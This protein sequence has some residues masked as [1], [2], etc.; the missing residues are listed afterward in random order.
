MNIKNNRR[1]K[2]A[3]RLSIFLILF[4]AIGGGYLIFSGSAATQCGQVG[5]TNI[6][7]EGLPSRTDGSNAIPSMVGAVSAAATSPPGTG[8]C[9][10][11]AASAVIATAITSS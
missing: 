2:S 5:L 10:L 3:N 8:S 7:I 1:L 4:S 6:T 9:F 11:H